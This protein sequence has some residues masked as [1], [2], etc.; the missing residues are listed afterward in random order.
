MRVSHSNLSHPFECRE[1]LQKLLKEAEND[2]FYDDSAID[3]SAIS[4]CTVPLWGTTHRYGLIRDF[5]F[6]LVGGGL[7]V[8]GWQ[9]KEAAVYPYLWEI[10]F[11]I[12]FALLL[13]TV[14]RMLSFIV[15]NSLMAIT[16][17][18][19]F[20]KLYYY[21]QAWNGNI[22]LIFWSICMLIL[23]RLYTTNVAINVGFVVLTVVSIVGR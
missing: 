3:T 18:C 17:S 15:L 6:L 1:E 21:L 11:L 20:V 5:L 12:G 8:A 22:N 4:C 2:V 7:A 14:C 16:I 19:G 13:H 10:P 23:N 9:M